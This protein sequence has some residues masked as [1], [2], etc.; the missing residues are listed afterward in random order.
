[1]YQLSWEWSLQYVHCSGETQYTFSQSHRFQQPSVL[2]WHILANMLQHVTTML[3]CAAVS[4]ICEDDLGA[5]CALLRGL[6]H[7][8]P[9]FPSSGPDAATGILGT[10]IDCGSDANSQQHAPWS[11]WSSSWELWIEVGLYMGVSE[12]SVPL[13]PMVNDHYPY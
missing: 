10:S 1:M 6:C 11:P 2:F 5:H 12:N 9:L 13:N 3:L 7:W 8:H 4:Q